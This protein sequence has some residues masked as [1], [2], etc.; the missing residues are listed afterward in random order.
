MDKANFVFKMTRKRVTYIVT[1]STYELAEKEAAAYVSFHV[2][3]S[4]A[5]FGVADLFDTTFS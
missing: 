3:I 4:I 2:C 1:L 5:V